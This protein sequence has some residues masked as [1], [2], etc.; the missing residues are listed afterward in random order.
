[1]PI[2]NP[3]EPANAQDERRIRA[4]IDIRR[5]FCFTTDMAVK[6]KALNRPLSCMRQA[7]CSGLRKFDS[8]IYKQYYAGKCG[9]A[10]RTRKAAMGVPHHSKRK[11]DKGTNN[12]HD[13]CY[14][15]LIHLFHFLPD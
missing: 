8:C 4:A 2:A 1:M 14:C 6:P 3:A 5:L 13:R 7:L 11:S 15:V 12:V 10:H 9:Q